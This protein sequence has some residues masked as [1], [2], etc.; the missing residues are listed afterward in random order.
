MAS[1]TNDTHA[2]DDRVSSITDWLAPSRLLA[3]AGS[4]KFTV[5]LFAMSIVLV[6]VGTLA[7]DEMNMQEVKQRYFLSWIAPLHL[8]DFF[9][10]AFYRHSQPI[11]GIL[12]FPGG[13]MIGM[14]L[15]VNLIAA[16]ITRFRLQASGGRLFAGLAF[17]VA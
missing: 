2:T 6:L 14:L 4:L 5:A 13:A 11:P 7:Q 9:P 15:M 17:L 16:K 1:V 8:D 10:Q 12:P 3:L